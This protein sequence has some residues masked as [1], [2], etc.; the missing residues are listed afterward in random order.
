MARYLE[1]HFMQPIDEA[2]KAAK[3]GLDEIDQIVLM[4]AGTRMPRIQ[5]LLS[6]LV[7]GLRKTFVFC[8][9]NK[10]VI[11]RK[12]LGRFLNTDEAIALGA[13]YHAAALQKGFRVKRF[14]VKVLTLAY[15][16][17]SLL[18]SGGLM[19]KK[20]KKLTTYFLLVVLSALLQI[21]NYN[22]Q[23]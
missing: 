15:L 14:D 9:L 21:L 17:F 12:E 18:F 19:V 5:Q 8:S 22:V 16:L 10:F 6:D 23:V 1:P 7:K 13:V 4:G 3:L 2:I 11:L 20:F